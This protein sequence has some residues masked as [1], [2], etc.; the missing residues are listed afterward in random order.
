MAALVDCNAGAQGA[1]AAGELA[2]DPPE[3]AACCPSAR[4]R[5]AWP[6]T[7][8]NHVMIRKGCSRQMVVGG[9]SRVGEV[10]VLTGEATVHKGRELIREFFG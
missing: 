3:A 5:S 9:K 1:E 10:G 8:N 4:P 6:F 7:T 2:V